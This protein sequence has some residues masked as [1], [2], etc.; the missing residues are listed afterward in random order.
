MYTF[1]PNRL[2][3]ANM[4]LFI[5]SQDCQTQVLAANGNHRNNR[6]KFM[7]FVTLSLAKCSIAF[8]YNN[9]SDN[10]IEIRYFGTVRLLQAKTVLYVN[11]E[12]MDFLPPASFSHA[13]LTRPITM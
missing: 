6:L 2:Y 5:I 13:R 7:I 4:A 12:N 10:K 9:P 11:M 1:A 3:C 8:A